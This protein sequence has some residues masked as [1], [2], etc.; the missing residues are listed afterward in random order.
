MGT[1]PNP[2]QL[3]PDGA[4]DLSFPPPQYENDFAS[5]VGNAATDSDG[6]DSLYL[7]AMSILSEYPLFAVGLDIAL[8]LIDSSLPDVDIPW[9]EDFASTLGSFITQGDPDFAQFNVDMTGNS[10][11]PASSPPGSNTGGTT[12]TPAGAVTYEAYI[13]VDY[14]G[15]TGYESPDY[16]TLTIEVDPDAQGRTGPNSGGGANG[17]GGTVVN[18]RSGNSLTVNL[19]KTSF[20]Q[21]T[22]KFAFTWANVYNDK[23]K[24]TNATL[25]PAEQTVWAVDL[26]KFI[27]TTK[28]PGEG[29]VLT[30][31]FTPPVA[32]S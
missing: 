2:L 5:I 29:W 1:L 15:A 27:G 26:S 22:T 24:I 30:A 14:T 18:T 20:G 6:F 13:E 12:P 31:E 17:L 21:P 9:E 32:T 7:E 23:I 16:I 10:P 28:Q 19:P 25:G 3:I 4:V 8:G 11:P